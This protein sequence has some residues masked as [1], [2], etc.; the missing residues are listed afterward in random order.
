MSNV[1][2]HGH[3]TRQLTPS[4]NPIHDISEF[5]NSLL[6]VVTQPLIQEW[7]MSSCR[8]RWSQSLWMTVEK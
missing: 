5:I 8:D 4:D 6:V 1:H 3:V 7:L 2:I